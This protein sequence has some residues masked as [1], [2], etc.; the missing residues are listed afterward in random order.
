MPSASRSP[1]LA[2]PEVSRLR[3]GVAA[4]AAEFRHVLAG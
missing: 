3:D 4:L 1:L 2:G